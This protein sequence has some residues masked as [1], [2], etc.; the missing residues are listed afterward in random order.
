MVEKIYYA[1]H[2]RSRRSQLL[3]L[4]ECEGEIFDIHDLRGTV[5]RLTERISIVIVTPTSHHVSSDHPSVRARGKRINCTL[6]VT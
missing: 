4:L 1:G 2:E 5:E 3:E 6:D